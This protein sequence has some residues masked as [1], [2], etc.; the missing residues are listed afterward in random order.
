MTLT[1]QRI[2]IAATVASTLALVA[3]GSDDGD[4]ND[5]AA[6]EANTSS[7]GSTGGEGDGDGLETS[8]IV[9]TATAAGGF[10]VLLAALDA[11]SL[12]A[13]LEGE[14]PFTVFAPSDAA[15]EAFESANPGVLESLS[16]EELADVL[17][18]HVVAGEVRSSDLVS[19]SL[20]ETLNGARAAVDLS[21]GTM[22]AGAE[23]V[24]A[25]IVASNGVIHVIGSLMLPPSM[26]IVETAVDA[27]SFT[28]LAGA[29][30]ATGLDETLSGDGPFTVFAP[31]DDAFAAFEAANPGVLAA[32]S[33]AE[34]TNVLLYHVVP[35][36]AGPADL[37]DGLVVGTALEG[38]SVTVSLNDGV[39][40]D[41][42]NVTA[43]NIV[44]TN[45]VIHV[46]DAVLL[47]P[48]D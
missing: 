7:G 2:S 17:T 32:L 5:S 38:A 29:L 4:D 18:Y 1:L 28:A 22:I 47:P 14:G 6:G 42:A 40:V 36:W 16:K 25:D 21:D 35:G 43:T 44:A 9:E 27:G 33:E 26:N 3:C 11:T 12:T 31:T 45:G 23:V 10:T 19:G 41:D 48:S 15:F 13:A 30:V 8:N 34:L 20:V 46:I 39:M 24:S 37:S